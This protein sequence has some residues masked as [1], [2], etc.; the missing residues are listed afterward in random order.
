[1]VKDPGRRKVAGVLLLAGVEP[2]SARPWG[3][4]GFYARMRIYFMGICG[5]AMGNAAL[6]MRSLGHE[7]LGADTGVYPPMS[8][9]LRAAGIEILEGWSAERLAQLKPDLVVVGNVASRGHPEVEWLLEA[10]SQPYVSLPE[11]LRTR[12]LNE[13]RNIVVAGTHGKTTTTCMAA[14]LLQANGANPGWLVG[15]VPRDLPDSSHPGKSGGPFVIEGD[16]YDTAFFDKRSKFIQ[17]LP[18]V[19]AINNCEFDHADIFRDL[20]DVL[21]T[22]SHVIR[23]VPRDGAIVANGD[24]ANVLGLVKNVTWAPVIRVGTGADNDAVIADF[25][26]T[27]TGSSFTLHWKG[28]EWGRVQWALP[29]LFNARNAA[30]AAVSAGLLLDRQD[31]TK[32]KLEALAKFQ[33]VMRRQQVL[34]DRADRVVIEDFGHHPTALKLTLESL[35]ARY[36]QHRLVACFEPRSNTA[37]RKVMQDAFRDALMLADD[38]YLAPAHRADTLGGESFD[39]TGV[40]AAISASGRRGFAPA[41][42][43]ALLDTLR[44][45]TAEGQGARCIVFF[46]NGAFGGIIKKFAS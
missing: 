34:V 20:D 1:M 8:D 36:P 29:G 42:N 40:A 45:H 12:L 2:F 43:D 4:S 18:H 5:T 33:G 31:P 19:L 6:L 30:M 17:Y 32:L 14:V 39:S 41:S 11:L 38:V 21:R 23:I 28:R 15:G 22:F 16:E 44:L 35:R 27:S 13:R 3:R 24:D 7:V 37:A 25:K 9:H 46:S 26:E 10:R